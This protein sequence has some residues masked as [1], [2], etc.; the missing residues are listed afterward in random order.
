M[1]TLASF[2]L[3]IQINY[4][5]F[6]LEYC[7]INLLVLNMTVYPSLYSLSGLTVSRP[8]YS[9]LN[10]S[11]RSEI[12]SAVEMP[13][14]FQSDTLI[15]TPNLAASRLREIWWSDVLPLSEQRPR[16]HKGVHKYMC[17]CPWYIE[18]SRLETNH[19]HHHAL[20]GTVAGRF[21]RHRN[22]DYTTGPMRLHPTG[23][24]RTFYANEKLTFWRYSEHAHTHTH[25]H[26][27][28]W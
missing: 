5:V 7:L 2:S 25:T 26:T 21:W 16:C 15:I 19:V 22:V 27:R 6:V 13:V 17:Y 1:N 24:I 18:S 8:W 3:W 23:I 4:P 14:K 11:N 20:F 12:C 10:F 28:M 9:G